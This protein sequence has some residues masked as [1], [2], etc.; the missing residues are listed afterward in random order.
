EGAWDQLV[1]TDIRNSVRNRIKKEEENKPYTAGQHETLEAKLKFCLFSDLLKM[2]KS[3][4]ILFQD[5]FGKEALLDQY[6]NFAVSAR[7]AIKHG[8]DLSNVDLA[9]A[10]AGLLWL[11]ECLHK[12]K[13]EEESAEEMLAET[14]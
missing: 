11:E 7:N 8:N 4:W 6:S 2:I 5:V 14:A 12:V 10:E 9:S 1:S 13:V 3:N